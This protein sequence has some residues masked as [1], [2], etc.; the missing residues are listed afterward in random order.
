MQSHLAGRYRLRERIGRG[1]MASVW[2]ARDEVLVRDV[3]VKLIDPEL[4]RDPEFRRRFRDE[5]RAAAALSHP[6]IVTVHDYGESE[7]T[8]YIVM[9]LLTGSTLADL[10]PVADA[11][12]VIGQ[13]ASALAA[14][15]AARIVHRDIKPTNVFVTASGVKVLDFGI[16]GDARMGTPDY[17]PPE[18]DLSPSADVY[19]LGIVWFE[20]VKGHRPEPGETLGGLQARCVARSAADRPTAAEVAAALGADAEP[21]AGPGA[22]TPRRPA[23]PITR[24]LTAPAV[25][26]R[27]VPMAA[28]AAA[29]IT[30]AVIA[31]VLSSGDDG[32]RAALTAPSGPVA[33]TAPSSA[34]PRTSEPVTPA[35]DARTPGSVT[36]AAPPPAPPPTARQVRTRTAPAPAGTVEALT[37]MRRT[38][39]EGTAAREVRSDVAVD[40]D[41]IITALT[42]EVAAGRRVDLRQRITDLRQKIITR[43][44]EGGLTRGRA[45]ALLRELPSV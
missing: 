4:A 34:A 39:D 42:N 32:S 14:A 21:V 1:G 26:R 24:V 16:A 13:I 5:A 19:S 7:D 10:R 29:A 23:H 35:P 27:R 9:E 44:G 40:L 41:N 11:E 31:V 22:V 37:R 30:A 43:L 6:H 45:D 38:V 2:L 20:A 25:R 15:H 33:S 28:G 3:A 8:P 12:R 18:N 36:S 17:L